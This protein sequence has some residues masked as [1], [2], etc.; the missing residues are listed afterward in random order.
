MNSLVKY[1]QMQFPLHPF[2]LVASGL[3]DSFTFTVQ[4]QIFISSTTSSP[5]VSASAFKR[6]FGAKMLHN[7]VCRQEAGLWLWEKTISALLW[8][9]MLENVST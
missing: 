6:L 2:A 3:V 1:L 8:N 4:M 7:S 5:I 9:S